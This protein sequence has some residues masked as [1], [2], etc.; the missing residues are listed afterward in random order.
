MT[1]A[2]RSDRFR[3]HRFDALSEGIRIAGRD[4]NGD[5][6]RQLGEVADRGGHQRRSARHRL[7]RGQSEAFVR[8]G[9]HDDRGLP[10]QRRQVGVLDRSAEDQAHVPPPGFGGNAVGL[11]A[12]R[13]GEGKRRPAA[14]KPLHRLE[15]GVESLAWVA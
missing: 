14:G 1:H 11:R 10:V 15:E 13:A 3:E 12:E 6:K 5:V 8:R 9:E 2:R 7:E 4:E